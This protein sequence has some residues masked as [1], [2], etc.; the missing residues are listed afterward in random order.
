M[1]LAGRLTRRVYPRIPN[2]LPA[3]MCRFILAATKTNHTAKAIRAQGRRGD[4]LR[5]EHHER[6]GLH[7][8]YRGTGA[9]CLSYRVRKRYIGRQGVARDGCT[10]SLRE[11]TENMNQRTDSILRRAAEEDSTATGACCTTLLF[12]AAAPI[13]PSPPLPPLSLFL[14]A[15][16]SPW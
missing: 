2:R 10:E 1:I 7:G 16:V 9:C 13:Y 15:P 14:C 6:T 11:D 5:P 3:S 8:R 12:R 4:R